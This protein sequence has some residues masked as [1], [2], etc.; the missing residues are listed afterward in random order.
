MDEYGHMLKASARTEDPSAEQ[1]NTSF[2]SNI[3]VKER[4]GA[5]RRQLATAGAKMG[6]AA[7][8]GPTE[9]G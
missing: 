7:R 3:N 9:N 1:R 2:M 4:Q 6:P 8:Q 5:R